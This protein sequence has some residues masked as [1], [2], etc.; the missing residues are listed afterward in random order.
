MPIVEIE[1]APGVWEA[2]DVDY[3]ERR[4]LVAA[5]P[6]ELRFT[7]PHEDGGEIVTIL[8]HPSYLTEEE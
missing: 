6:A 5:T 3:M 4:R 2:R 7:R 8:R 1:T